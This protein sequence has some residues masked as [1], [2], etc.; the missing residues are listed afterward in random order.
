M[1]RWTKF[2]GAWCVK[3]PRGLAGST[4]VVSRRNGVA[5]NVYLGCEIAPGIY[6]TGREDSQSRLFDPDR[7][8]E[9]RAMGLDAYGDRLDR[10]YDSDY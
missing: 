6:S 9:M 8:S 1:A 2:D 7:V 3:A 5:A 4:V 10:P